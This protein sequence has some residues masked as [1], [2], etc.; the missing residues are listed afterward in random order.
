MC[1]EVACTWWYMH[2]LQSASKRWQESSALGS[3]STPFTH[4]HH[5]NCK[6]AVLN[7]KHINQALNDAQ[8][9]GRQPTLQPD[10]K[11]TD[12]TVTAMYHVQV[13]SREI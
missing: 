10:L 9:E 13:C 5:R 2:V 6:C 1:S 4:M 7:N 3:S 8:R 11:H 12:S